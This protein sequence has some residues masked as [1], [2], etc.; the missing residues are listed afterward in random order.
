MRQPFCTAAAQRQTDARLPA[1]AAAAGA[2]QQD[3][4]STEQQKVTA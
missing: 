1:L 2:G 3:G 4:G